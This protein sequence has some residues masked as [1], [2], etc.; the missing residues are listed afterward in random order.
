MGNGRKIGMGPET[1]VDTKCMWEDSSHLY[2]LNVYY[3]A[4]NVGKYFSEPKLIA[5]FGSCMSLMSMPNL[6]ALSIHG[7]GSNP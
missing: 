3:L 5:T 4:M 1:Q 7:D 2:R 6:K